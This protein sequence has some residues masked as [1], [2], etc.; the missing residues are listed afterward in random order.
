MTA[1]DDNDLFAPEF[2]ANR[3]G[4]LQ[5]LKMLGRDGFMLR[6]INEASG[7]DC[8][9]SM[10]GAA[11]RGDQM[12]LLDHPPHRSTRPLFK[13]GDAVRLLWQ[14]E[15]LQFG[16]RGHVKSV[17][18]GPI[19]LLD[20][21]A[22]LY[23]R[24]RR[25]SYRVPVSAMDGVTAELLP[26][27]TLTAADDNM[28]LAVETGEDK[29]VTVRVSDISEGGLRLRLTKKQLR[30]SRVQERQGRE[31]HIQFAK[32]LTAAHTAGIRI[33]WITPDEDGDHVTIGARWLSPSEEFTNDIQK[34]VVYKQRLMIQR[35]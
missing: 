27:E 32:G 11:P 16:A 7:L 31:L 25:R 13:E 12:F 15:G 1:E 17:L 34:F 28:D 33:V 14:R 9:T 6:A 24:Q 5:M 30:N 29:P 18:E 21:D 35:R 10:G 23:R 26:D 22:G 19:Y 3:A 2:T 8:A 4:R 20:L